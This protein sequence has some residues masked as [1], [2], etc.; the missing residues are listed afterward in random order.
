MRSTRANAPLPV[1]EP[2]P[3][4][5]KPA[6]VRLEE[7]MA[8]AEKLFLANGVEATTI[9]SIVEEAN[10]A[11]GTFYH[12]FAAKTDMLAALAERYTRQ[13]LEVL[14]GAVNACAGDDWVGKL[15]AWI[16]ASIQT[17]VDT[18]RTHDIVYG[19]HHHHDRQN[20]DKNAI[21]DQLLGIL[22]GGKTAALWALPQPRITALLIYSGVHGVA[23]DAIAAKLKDCTDFAR[24]VSD[25]CLRMLGAPVAGA[26]AVKRTA[27]AR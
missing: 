27:K 9:S 25:D 20:R 23:D 2:R 1:S 14:E 13:Y 26:A 19:N 10:V 17:Y 6:E 8:A 22:E 11:K 7:L 16:H 21:L 18:Y 4:R 5:T 15:Q 3:P 24:S 12:Y